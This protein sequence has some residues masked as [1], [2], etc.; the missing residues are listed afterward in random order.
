MSPDILDK[1]IVELQKIYPHNGWCAEYNTVASFKCNYCTCI[2]LSCQE[3][4]EISSGV[5]R[6]MKVMEEYDLTKEDWDS[7]IEVG[8]FE[9]HRD[10]VA[11]IP[12]KVCICSLS[13]LV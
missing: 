13:F 1:Q 5:S 11:S 10:P 8:Q 3:S 9:G 7:I 2:I 6:V 12:S 4:D